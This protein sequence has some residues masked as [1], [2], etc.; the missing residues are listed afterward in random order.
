MSANILPPIPQPVSV[1]Y[2]RDTINDA[3]ERVENW[4]SFFYENDERFRYDV[5][6]ALN[7]QWDSDTLTQRNTYGKP[8]YTFNFIYTHLMQILGEQQRNTM[9]LIV[10][11]RNEEVEQDKINL[12]EGLMRNI[13]YENNFD[14]V[15]QVA[16][17]YALL[18]GYGAIK[19]GYDYENEDS[20]NKVIK[21]HQITDP[22]RCYWDRNIN[23]VDK[24][25]GDF[26]GYLYRVTKKHF[27]DMY[28]DL[29]RPYSFPDYYQ[30][31]TRYVDWVTNDDIVVAEDYKKEYFE[32]TLVLLSDG[33]SHDK[34]DVQDYIE[35]FQAAQRAVLDGVVLAPPGFDAFGTLEVTEE[36][37]VKDWKIM[38]RKLV[39]NEILEESEF[40]GKE[41]PIV[42]VDGDS[43]YDG[44][45]Q[46]IHSFAKYAFDDQRL[47]NYV[48]NEVAIHVNNSRKEKWLGTPE[49][50]E[51]HEDE[52]RNP[53][54]VLG[55]LTAKPDPVT[56]NMPNVVQPPPFP[57]SLVGLGENIQG[58]IQEILGRYEAVRGAQ[59]AEISGTAIASRIAQGNSTS[60]VYFKN[61]GEAVE[62]VGRIMLGMIPEV[63][64]TQREV[65]IKGR[66]DELTTVTINSPS[67]MNEYENDLTD[68][69]YSVYLQAGPSFEV[70]KAE[71]LKLLSQF[72]SSNPQLQMALADKIAANL[73]LENTEEIV[74]TT[75]KV[76]ELILPPQLTAE[77]GEPIPPPQPNPELMI[78]QDKL[79]IQ[80]QQE[81]NRA[82]EN[83][84]KEI[85]LR[86]Q[87]QK[88]KLDFANVSK[89][90]DAELGK[91]RIDLMGDLLKHQTE[92]RKL[93]MERRRG[94]LDLFSNE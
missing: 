38:Q 29:P 22:T 59:G 87:A 39:Y 6:F 7:Q 65:T 14:R 43:T 50:F 63:Y 81:A 90:T 75:K 24:N 73:N 64:D 37:R 12:V 48:M 33:T 20:F 23:N 79:R 67:G 51:G 26:C 54:R 47:Y 58:N 41:L 85:Q 21:I 13:M 66:D 68:L 32:K 15:Q 70:Q 83:R 76:Q 91:A 31:N 36:R 9:D 44:D 74:A 56:G 55:A 4:R 30:G 93:N 92:N 86:L 69:N 1:G 60:F 89:K 19:I 71:E 5:R 34:K 18:G 72:A 25:K 57:T 94:L 62:K 49:N 2:D 53:D 42:F 77:E 11:G 27:E 35:K 17:R 28:P 10:R 84:I 16:F 45:E 78:E 82:E 46:V 8:S 3:I 40:P 61:L 52:W 80:A 88:Q